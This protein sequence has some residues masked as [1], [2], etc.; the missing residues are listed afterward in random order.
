MELLA[1]L[2]RTPAPLILLRKDLCC[3]SSDEIRE[4]I[5]VLRSR[6][7]RIAIDR[8]EYGATFRDAAY[9]ASPSAHKIAQADALNYWNARYP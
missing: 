6:G 7:H 9:M 3:N 2:S 5:D 4:M 1:S 8:I